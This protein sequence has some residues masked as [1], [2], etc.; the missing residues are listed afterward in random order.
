MSPLTSREIEENSSLGDLPDLATGKIGIE[1]ALEPELRGTP[2]GERVDNADDHDRPANIHDP[3]FDQ[4]R[5][6]PAHA[7]EIV[8]KA[9][10]DTPDR[11]VGISIHVDRRRL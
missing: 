8:R 11:A 1:Y 9:G 10:G 3:T 5:A 4:R 7:P 2:G 6:A